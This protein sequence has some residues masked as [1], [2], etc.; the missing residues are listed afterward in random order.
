MFVRRSLLLLFTWF[1]V[2]VLPGST[3]WGEK[4]SHVTFATTILDSSKDPIN[5][6]FKELISQNKMDEL[7]T[8]IASGIDINVADSKR[9]SPIHYAAYMG[10]IEAMRMLIR[11]GVNL[12]AAAFGGWTAL[13]YASFGGHTEIASLL[14]S[15]G[16]PVDIRD[17]GGESPL[18][19]AIEADHPDMVRWLVEHGANVSHVNNKKETPL[20]VAK[21]F[22]NKEI[23]GYLQKHLKQNPGGKQPDNA[24]Q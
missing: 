7:G 12:W 22:N 13:H 3:S 20:S 16:I 19:Y 8:Y 5:K 23:I 15:M 17:V 21:E 14:V 1:L 24:N 2:G 18:F 10:S 9:V 6:K 11:R 4:I